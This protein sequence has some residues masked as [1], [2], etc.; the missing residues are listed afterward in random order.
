MDIATILGLIVGAAM[1]VMSVLTSGGTMG[2]IID[3]PSVFM[4]IGGSYCAMLI[5]APLKKAIGMFKIMAKAFKVPDFGEKKYC[6]KYAGS[7]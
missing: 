3:I 4:T 5:A 7:F 6:N 1:I 2:G